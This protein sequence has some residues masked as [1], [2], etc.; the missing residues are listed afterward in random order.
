[1]QPFSR[2]ALKLNPK[3]EVER[4]TKEIRTQV[5]DILRRRGV[6]IGLSGGID[7]SVSAALLVKALGPE[8]VFGLMM[9]E[10]ESADESLPLAQNLAHTLGI[11]YEVESISPLLDATR[12]YQRRD[13]AICVADP[14]F[15]EGGR[16][17]LVIR[18]AGEDALF[19][20]FSIVTED[21]EGQQKNTRLSHRTYLEIV[22]ASNFKQRARKMLEYYHADRLHYAVC[23]TPNRL[24]YDQGFFV[25]N[26]DGA[27]DL[28]PIAHLYKS[29]VY[30]LAEE[31]QIPSSIRKRPPTT[32]TYSLP[33][34]QEEFY[35]SLPYDQ[36]DL[37][38][39]G[40]D[41]DVAPEAVA[42]EL[43]IPSDAVRRVYRDIDTKRRTTGYL[44]LAPLLIHSRERL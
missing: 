1:M 14:T 36:M 5:K 29:Q 40:V 41:H 35:F 28:K 15:E 27:A 32:D 23:G 25:K 43:G 9:P 17:K 18:S 42:M 22:A 38:L 13:Q 12:C 4:I 21:R 37:C 7:S 39:Y 24:E 2:D 6:V 19:H 26:G 11:A 10:E 16:S 33:Q 44:H 8:R 3:I 34:S 20:F 31:L 30:Q